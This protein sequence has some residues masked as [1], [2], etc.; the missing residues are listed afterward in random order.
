MA[1]QKK[2]NLPPPPN[3]DADVNDYAWRDW[4]RQLRDYI[5]N[6]GTI[7]WSQIDF[8]GSNIKDIVTRK[9]NDLQSMQ[10]GNS[11]LNEYYHF[12]NVQYTDLTDGGETTLH[13]HKHN[14]TTDKQ[15]GTTNEYYHL[16]S[17]QHTG[18]TGGNVTLLHKHAYYGAFQDNTT[19]TAAAINTAYAMT[20][21]T[22]DY[23]SGVD[24]GTPTSRLVVAN[25]GIY[26][27]QFSAQ[28]QKT[29]ASVGY[30]WIWIR[31]SGTDVVDSTTKIAVQGSTAET[32]AAWNWFIE[33][34]ANDYVE[35]MWEVDSTAIKLLHET[36]TAIHPAIPSVIATINKINV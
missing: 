26:N 23:S 10:G 32:V 2:Y 4:F 18:L 16:T 27:V 20:F 13:T 30:I 9:H 14:N 33:L 3:P 36:S 17:S 31:K 25:A 34:A 19:Q 6:K 7:L 12:S 35:I 8:T 11:L 24:R 5:V 28:I 15:G 29:S 22:T 21:D 1:L